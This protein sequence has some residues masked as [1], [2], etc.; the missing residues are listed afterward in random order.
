MM[1]DR[2]SEVA[3]VGSAQLSRLIDGESEPSR[4]TSTPVPKRTVPSLVR[5]ALGLLL[6]RPSLAARAGP[7]ERL[8]ELEVPGV[9]L[10]V[11]VLELLLAQPQLSMSGL[12]ERWRGTEAGKLLDRLAQESPV[13]L[14]TTAEGIEAEFA[15]ALQRLRIQGIEQ[16]MEVLLARGAL[17]AP[18]EWRELQPELQ[19]LHRDKLALQQSLS[20]QGRPAH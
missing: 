9:A 11:E 7:L 2:L 13:A 16:R 14:E 5:R 12:L 4:R 1:F 17:L 10:L 8:R 6:H 19:Q 20:T 15:D 18:D 3:S